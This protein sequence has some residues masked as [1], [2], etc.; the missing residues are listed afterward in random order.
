MKW[1]RARRTWDKRRYFE[2]VWCNGQGETD[3]RGGKGGAG[4]HGQEW[5]GWFHAILDSTPRGPHLKGMMGPVCGRWIMLLELGTKQLRTTW[6]VPF[7]RPG[8][9]VRGYFHTT[10]SSLEEHLWSF[11]IYLS[12]PLPLLSRCYLNWCLLL[13]PVMML[14]L[15]LFVALT[16]ACPHFPSFPPHISSWPLSDLDHRS[17]S[18]ACC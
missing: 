4:G 5:S 13:L 16:P 8:L 15:S 6:A 3:Q 9:K 18:L 12:Y 17:L 7:E 11:P 10:H 14:G 1:V 2:F